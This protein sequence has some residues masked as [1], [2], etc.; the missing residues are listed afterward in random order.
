MV[1]LEDDFGVAAGFKRV[2]QLLQFASKFKVV[3]DLA[4]EDH[5]QMLKEVG[6][7]GVFA[8]VHN[9]QVIMA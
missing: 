1:A 4:V 7:V 2:A 9:L 5:R 6:L 8:Q 3:I